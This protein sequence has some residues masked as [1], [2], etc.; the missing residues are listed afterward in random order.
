MCNFLVAVDDSRLIER[1]FRLIARLD[2]DCEKT[3]VFMWRGK[4]CREK[5]LEKTR[6][7]FSIYVESGY[8]I[9]QSFRLTAFLMK[10]AFSGVKKGQ[11]FASDALQ[12]AKK[13]S[14]LDLLFEISIVL[15]PENLEKLLQ[16][17]FIV[18]KKNPKNFVAVAKDKNFL[19]W[20]I[21]LI[22]K[23]HKNEP[24]RGLFE[25]ANKVF[26]SYSYIFAAGQASTSFLAQVAELI[27][28]YSF[29]FRDH[30]LRFILLKNILKELDSKEMILTNEAALSSFVVLMF[31]Y[32]FINMADA[33]D[34][35]EDLEYFSST[36][37]LIDYMH[38]TINLNPNVNVAGTLQKPLSQ[39]LT[40]RLNFSLSNLTGLSQVAKPGKDY[41][42]K[43]LILMTLHIL[44]KQVNGG[45]VSD[46]TT[47]FRFVNALFD[48]LNY[49]LE[50]NRAKQKERPL[51]LEIALYYMLRFIFKNEASKQYIKEIKEGLYFYADKNTHPNSFSSKF[52]AAVG[53]KAEDAME[54]FVKKL[55]SISKEKNLYI[56][57]FEDLDFEDNQ[58]D[59]ILHAIGAINRN[60]EENN[61]TIDDGFF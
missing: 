32:Y 58:S 25:M 34:E 46:L 56:E 41:P 50:N 53:A 16:N 10:K 47:G 15:E 48:K 14:M 21:V 12:I 60:L 30:S 1:T 17:I 2:P 52:C 7:V 8:M 35:A 54:D 5:C 23:F 29:A 27:H 57:E 28:F 49:A 38:K 39:T 24:Q 37:V 9:S 33:R 13:N 55:F 44:R 40:Q 19:N 3:L 61:A 11:V 20:I 43:F 26:V 6:K 59:Y 36:A 4:L 51:S 18:M 22:F 45:S 31:K 42:L